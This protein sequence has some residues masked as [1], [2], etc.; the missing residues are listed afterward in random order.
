MKNNLVITDILLIESHF[1]LKRLPAE[2]MSIYEIIDTGIEHTE[3]NSLVVIHTIQFTIEEI[4]SKEPVAETFFKYGINI[5]NTEKY[6]ED[7]IKDFAINQMNQLYL[8]KANEF[9]TASSL[10]AAKAGDIIIKQ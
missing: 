3:D 6:T 2:T 9:F 7:E 8:S 5:S 1:S 4:E 10:P